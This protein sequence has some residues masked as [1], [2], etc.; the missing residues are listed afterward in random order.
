MNSTAATATKR[1]YLSPPH[2]GP[3]EL[4]L[5]KEAFASNWIAPLGPHVDAFEKEFARLV[6]VAHAAALSSGTPALHLALRL[7]GVGPG[8]T[9]LCPTLTFCASANPLGYAGAA[10]VLI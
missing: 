4:E 2:L 7:L 6:G 3:D 10:P 5:V 9:V 8:D 1:I